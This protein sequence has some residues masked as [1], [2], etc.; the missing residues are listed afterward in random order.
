LLLPV[1]LVAL[2]RMMLMPTFAVLMVMIVTVGH[3]LTATITLFLAA[4][5]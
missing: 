1:R 3:L 5:R 2:V 4:E